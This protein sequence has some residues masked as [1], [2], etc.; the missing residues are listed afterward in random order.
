MAID[1][2]R[3]FDEAQAP[4]VQEPRFYNE[5]A[6]NDSGRPYLQLL[7]AERWTTLSGNAAK[8]FSN[9]TVATIGSGGRALATYA[10]PLATLRVEVPAGGATVIVYTGPLNARAGDLLVCADNL[11]TASCASNASVVSALRTS[12]QVVLNSS[13]LAALG[14]AGTHTLTFRTTTPSFLRIDGFQVIHGT[15]LA[16]GLYDETLA[17]TLLDFSPVGAGETDWSSFKSAKAFGGNVFRSGVNNATLTFDFEGTG[18]SIITENSAS[19]VDMRVCYKLESLGTAFPAAGSPVPAGITCELVTTDT[20][21][22]DWN[23]K[24]VDRP[25]VASSFQYGFAYYG[26]PADVYTVEVRVVDST[27]V[28]AREF[29]KIDAVGVFGDVTEGGVAA[30][31]G[32]GVYDDADENLDILY[33]PEPFWVFSTSARSGPPRGPFNRT[34]HTATNAGTLAQ[35]YVDGNALVIYQSGTSRNSSYVRV[36]LVV[37]G[38]DMECSEYSQNSRRAAYFTPVVIYGLGDD[39]HEVVIENRYPGRTFS[40][41]GIGV[42]P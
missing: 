17:G 37:P 23:T 24:N 42:L 13:N 26:L 4:L 7:P 25:L 34:E 27:I 19:G 5:N 33:G 20:T 2:V 14:V 16:P 12:S 18:F 38:D 39:E 32:P 15:T 31:T 10:G 11:S 28:A 35:V 22:A 6:T 1:Y 9:Q 41:D 29:L 3:I 8:L 40:I 21:P 30:P 36:C